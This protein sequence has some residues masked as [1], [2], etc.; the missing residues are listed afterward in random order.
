MKHLFTSIVFCGFAVLCRADGDDEFANYTI[1][2]RPLPS[3]ITVGVATAAYQIEGAWDLDGKGEQVWDTFVHEHPERIAGR[4]TGDVASDSYH[5]YK[6]DVACM[7]EVGVN[8]YRFSIAW[9][10]IL[11]NGTIDNINSAGIDY[12]LRLLKELE[13]N[14]IE[15][16]VT[17]YHWDIPTNLEKQGGWLNPKVVDWFE[18][19]ARLCYKVFGP[20]VKSWVTINEPKQI[21]HNGYGNGGFAPGIASPGVGEYICARH[22]L[23]AHAKAWRVFDTEFRASLKTRNT[24]VIDSDWYEPTTNSEADAIA[25][26]TKRQFVYGMYANPV[27]KGNWP[28]VMIDNVAK[29]SKAQGYNESRLPPFSDE[30]VELIKGTYDFIALN[31]YTSYMVSAIENDNNLKGV[32]WDD[33][34]GVNCYQKS[35]WPTAAAGWFKI[36][37]WG[38][39]KLLRWIKQT[40]GDIEIVIT[41][42]GVSDTTGTLR[43][44]H[45]IDYLR[46]YMSH[47][48][49]AIYD[50][51]VNLTA[52]TVWS[53]MDNFE[54]TQGFGAK[55]GMYYVNMSDPMRPRTAKDSSRYLANVIKT[56]C[57]LDSC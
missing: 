3:H 39:G 43:D 51:G 9:S 50:G 37:P 49:D 13:S 5:R 33:D 40:Y 17:L 36:V 52:Y 55:L 22:V 30:E 42:N 56:R 44:Q 48:I 38:F 25:A 28:Q 53:I 12:Y 57:L 15:A 27:I 4:A 1:T 19:Y 14:G 45:R 54:W 46:S 11:P 10:R 31:H 2:N 34:A 21:C 16:M 7:K 35:T 24:I 8:Y 6:E 23:L 18:D 20:Y 47:M 29:F 41:E 32:S 26:E